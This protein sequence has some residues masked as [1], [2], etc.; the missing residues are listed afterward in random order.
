MGKFVINGGKPLHGE[1]KVNGAKNSVLPIFAAS[2]LNAGISIIKNAPNISDT[3]NTIKILEHIGC[4]VLYND[5]TVII[6]SS[7][8]T[9]TEI[10]LEYTEKMRS[11]I[12]FLGSLCG[13]FKTAGIAY[14]GG[15]SLGARPIDLHIDALKKMGA[16]I[17]E[18]DNMINAATVSL[19]G[20]TIKLK[21]PSVGA[22]ENIM[23]AAVLAEG[24]TTIYN[25]A[26]EPEI[27]DL[28][29]FLNGMGA[30]INGAGSSK[31]SICGVKKLHSLE[32]TVMP[33]RIEAGTFL[34]AAALTSSSIALLGVNDEQ[35]RPITDT[36]T[37]I[38]CFIKSL[39]DILFISSPPIL[40]PIPQ[41]LTAPYPGFPTDMQPQMMAVLT[42]ANGTSIINETVFDARNKHIS[43]LN[44]MGGSIEMLDA[45]K[46]R[47]R[48]NS[49]LIGASVH[50]E[51]LRGGAALVIAAAAAIGQSVITGSTH[52]ERG[53]ERLDKALNSLGAD[54]KYIN[55]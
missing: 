17:T 37:K 39:D 6:D 54:I 48:G 24:I 53:Y 26:K 51:D 31:I 38:G 23:L 44:K 42:K 29:K 4:K 8:I 36:L 7:G 47:I 27:V 1:I 30:K 2:I 11:S 16:N 33:D 52:I 14:P 13:R 55:D 45:C 5:K 15:C 25:A 40:K 28:Q 49:K 20:C 21:Y 32:Y 43:Q 35:L 46:F 18:A 12:I 41:L 50:A 3:V 19:K 10:P 22:T 34:C 9:K